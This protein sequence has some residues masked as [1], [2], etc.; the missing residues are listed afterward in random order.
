MSPGSAPRRAIPGKL[1]F[2]IGE[3][4]EITGVQMYTLRYWER[5]FPTLRPKKN[6]AGQRSY[7]AEDIEMVFEIQRLLLEEGYTTAGAR[8]VLSG[9][10]SGSGTGSSK[11]PPAPVPMPKPAPPANVGEG[12]RLAAEAL[13]LMDETDA[14]LARLEDPGSGDESGDEKAR[15]DGRI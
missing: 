5:E 8:R 11:K 14:A 6:D 13:A 4:A 15:R 2:R 3:V 10:G 9:T 12:S 1:F 7:R